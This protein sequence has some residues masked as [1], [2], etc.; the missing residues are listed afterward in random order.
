M[1]CAYA[2]FSHKNV[3]FGQEAFGT[4]LGTAIGLRPIEANSKHRFDNLARIGL[5]DDDLAHIVIWLLLFQQ[6]PITLVC[7]RNAL[8]RSG[9]NTHPR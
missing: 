8:C 6:R 9:T 7:T 3:D 1:H 5:K 2:L 4:V